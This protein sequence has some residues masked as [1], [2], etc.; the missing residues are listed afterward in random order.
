MNDLISRSALLEEVRLSKRGIGKC[1]NHDYLVG[2]MSALSSV[3]GQIA[4]APAVDAEVV[5]C[6]NCVNREISPFTPKRMY[7]HALNVS[8]P[9]NL[10]FYCALGT[11]MDAE[12]EG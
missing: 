8:L 10:D 3:E 11:K 7:C 1:T 6:S 12:V 2:Y 5:R 4:A 9:S